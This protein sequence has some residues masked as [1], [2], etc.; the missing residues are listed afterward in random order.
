MNN[1]QTVK[2]EVWQVVELVR[3][4][5][6]GKLR[7]PDFQ[8]PFVWD[9]NRMLDLLDSIRRRYP[10]GSL[11]VWETE[12]QVSSKGNIGLI[13]INKEN[14]GSTSLVLDGH[15]RISTLTGALIEPSEDS[16]FKD[17]PDPG[18]WEIW[19]NAKEELF[20]HLRDNDKPEVWHFPMRKL[21]DTFSFLG[22]CQ[23]MLD[24]GG[25]EGP[26]FVQKTQ[27]LLRSFVDQQ[28][29]VVKIRNTDLSQAVNIFARL[30]STGKKSARTKWQRRLPTKKAEAL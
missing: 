7:I 2:P 30:N 21:I 13:K 8:R 19:F 16:I 22:E 26:H 18:R 9:R 25:K 12:E 11:L 17:D 27:E 10:I 3:D 6:G 1:N 4:A 20:E 23:R 29:P 15:Q 14:K 5:A 28:I 24:N